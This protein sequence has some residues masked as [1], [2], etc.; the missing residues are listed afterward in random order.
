MFLRVVFVRLL[1][2]VCHCSSPLGQD[3]D[4]DTALRAEVIFPTPSTM[5]HFVGL[6][7]SSRAFNNVPSCCLRQAQCCVSLQLSAG[8]GW[9]PKHGTSTHGNISATPSPCLTLAAFPFAPM[10]CTMIP[11][12]VFVRLAQ[13]RV[14]LHHVDQPLRR[15][16][17]GLPSVQVA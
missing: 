8:P 12:V 2:V 1:N 17:V 5:S 7:S 15:C 9:R 6:P 11:H 13:C 4:P 3:G 14:S 10:L 16:F